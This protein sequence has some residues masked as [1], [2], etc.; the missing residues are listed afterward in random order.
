VP[1]VRTASGAV[2]Q[3][4]G[5]FSFSLVIEPGQHQLRVRYQAQATRTLAY[6]SARLTHW[7]VD[8]ALAPAAGTGHASQ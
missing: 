3:T 8:Y 4:V 6:H 2:P 1:F 7:S 5:T